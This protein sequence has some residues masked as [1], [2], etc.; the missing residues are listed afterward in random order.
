MSL[1][2]ICKR[3]FLFSVL[4][5]SFTVIS[6]AQ[7]VEITKVEADLVGGYLYV[8][9]QNFGRRDEMNLKLSG[10]QLSI[11]VKSNVQLIAAL[12]AGTLPG[13]Y[14]LVLQK[15]RSAD[16]LDSVDVTIGN[17]GPSGPEGPQGP[18]G[19]AGPQGIQ[20]PMG[21][22]GAQG[23][24]GEIGP[25]GPAGAPGVQGETGPQG[26]AGPQGPQGN[27]GPQGPAGP[28]GPQGPQG[29]QGAQGPAGPTVAVFPIGRAAVGTLE[30]VGVADGSTPLICLGQHFGQTT[31]DPNWFGTGAIEFRFVVFGQKS[32]GPVGEDVYFDLCRG[33]SLGD[34]GGSLLVTNVLTGNPQMTDSG[35]Q[36]LTGSEPVRMNMRARRKV[37]AAG[38]YSHAYLLVR[39]AQ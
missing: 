21:P 3:S 27:P 12:P 18:Q 7:R 37:T 34:I 15:D 22:A 38:A 29:L 20:G 17:S 26:P 25:Q 23:V 39:P 9:G 14:R 31:I 36:T 4:L 11:L 30:G 33:S 32:G 6:N 2:A 13:T 1:A 16:I 24:Q 19:P 10:E 8:N 28:Q 5:L 35:W